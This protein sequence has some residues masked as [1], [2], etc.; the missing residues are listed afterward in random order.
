MGVGVKIFL[1]SWFSFFLD[2]LFPRSL[3]LRHCRD[4][5]G[6]RRLR[7]RNQLKEMK[8][9]TS[10]R[11][12]KNFSLIVVSAGPECPGQG[13]LPLPWDERKLNQT[14][15]FQNFQKFRPNGSEETRISSNFGFRADKLPEIFPG[16]CVSLQPHS[17]C[18]SGL[19]LGRRRR[20]TKAT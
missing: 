14:F 7:E 6:R 4:S 16:L 2:L 5:R 19:G 8:K 17:F 10:S 9:E 18:V 13:A 1:D 11:R 15:R 20:R 12:S 3:A